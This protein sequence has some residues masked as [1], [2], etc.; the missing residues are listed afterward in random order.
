MQIKCPQCLG[1]GT[2]EVGERGDDTALDWSK[3]PTASL[4]FRRI[5]KTCERC[6]GRGQ[7]DATDRLP[8][9]QDGRRIGSVPPNFNPARIRSLSWMYSPRAS[10][11]MRG[12]DAWIAAS[13]LGP[14]DLE[15][16][17]GFLW[18]RHD[19]QTQEKK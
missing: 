17:A 1:R 19:D 12:E 13:S 6:D 8:V 2:I 15:A 14:G 16:V 7:A 4:T 18:E 3:S 11:F 10:D 5:V 9:M